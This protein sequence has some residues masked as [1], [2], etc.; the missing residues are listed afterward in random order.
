MPSHSQVF[1]QFQYPTSPLEPFTGLQLSYL[2][3][4]LDDD[5]QAGVDALVRVFAR[6][7]GST[8]AP[9]AASGAAHSVRGSRGGSR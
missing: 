2:M 1:G 3:A 5:E 7:G 8:I 4:L 9:V 6:H